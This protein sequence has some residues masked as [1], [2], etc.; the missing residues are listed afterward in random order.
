MNNKDITG[1]AN[2]TAIA[3]FHASD[4]RL[5]ENIKPIEGLGILAKLRGVSFNWKKDGTPSAGVIA[6]EVEAVMPQAVQTGANGIKAVDYDQLIAPLI[7]AVKSQ[8]KQIELLARKIK[9][10]NEQIVG[11]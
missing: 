4:K 10:L 2:A 9:V 6:Q 5:K 7:E 3:Y 8:Q 1:I 11:K